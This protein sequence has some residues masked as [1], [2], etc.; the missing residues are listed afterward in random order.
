MFTR[1]EYAIL[2]EVN[3]GAPYIVNR[4]TSI[5]EAIYILE[6]NF[7]MEH[8]RKGKM[9]FVDNDF[10]KNSYNNLRGYKNFYYYKIVSRKITSWEDYNFF[11]DCNFKPKFSQNNIINFTNFSWH[12]FDFVIYIFYSNNLFKE[13]NIY[14]FILYRYII[15]QN[16]SKKR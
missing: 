15:A 2:C 7:I 11:E 6:H 14:P 10:Y 12:F 16:Q 13:G 1:I 4:F 5:T 8:E 3:G 9:F